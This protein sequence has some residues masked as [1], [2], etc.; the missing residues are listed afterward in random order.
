MRRNSLKYYFRTLNMFFQ[1]LL[2]LV[3]LGVSS[4]AQ[5][6]YQA[7]LATNTPVFTTSSYF[8]SWNIDSSRDR[9]FFFTNWSDPYLVQLAKNIGG[10]GNLRFG[11]TGNDALY[12]QVGSAPACG[13]TDP[14]IYECL[15]Q[16]WLDAL[17]SLSSASN[18]PLIFGVNIHPANASSPPTGVWD[19]TNAAALLQY[20]RSSGRPLFA[21]ELGNEQNTI[22]TAQE[23]AYA[24]YNLSS[25]LDQV[26]GSDPTRPFLVGPD[27]HSFHDNDSG[28]VKGLQYLQDFTTLA[29]PI[30]KAVTH[31]EYIEIDNIQVLNASFLD[32]SAR[33][34]KA[35]VEHVRAA[36]ATV[37][38]WAGEI[39]PHNGGTLPYPNCANNKVCGMFGSAIWYADSLSAKALAGYSSYCRQDFV[40]ADYALVNISSMTPTSDYWLLVLW[41][42]L[43]GTKVLNMTNSGPATLRTYAYCSSDNTNV[44]AVL[45]N[46][47]IASA[48]VGPFSFVYPGQSVNVFS[49]TPGEYSL[50]VLSPTI[51]LNSQ[52][53]QLNG[54]GT[55]PPLQGVS[56]SGTDTITL[57]PLSIT[58]VQAPSKACV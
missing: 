3:L 44:V 5:T 30:L 8:A 13:P 51:A 23:Q 27:T 19:P 33:I 14:Y 28:A 57:P 10:S 31:H 25:L 45:I 52:V 7:Q 39:G 9:L 20:M 53:L 6:C 16:T 41:K 47:D 18:S 26:Y 50:G 36:N 12:Y 38:I 40:G 58:F 2:L 11:G 43:I 37:E 15:N 34:A 46:L 49:L 42:Q 55:L 22:M 35:V 29:G 54:D 17:Y 48:C 32:A 1:S 56:V 24:L 21:L 4:V